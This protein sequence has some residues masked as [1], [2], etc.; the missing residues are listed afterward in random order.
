MIIVSRLV[1][2][3]IV[4]DIH[5]DTCV[6]FA[7]IKFHVICKICFSSLQSEI[8]YLFMMINLYRLRLKDKVTTKSDQTN[9]FWFTS[10]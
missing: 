4:V 10:N 2:R 7:Q 3:L 5:I 6:L 1:L 9:N 8:H